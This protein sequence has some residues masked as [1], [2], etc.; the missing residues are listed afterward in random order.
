MENKEKI[1][2]QINDLIALRSS[3]MTYLLVLT[4][5]LIGLFY[6]INPLNIFLLITGSLIGWFILCILSGITKKL[7]KLYK[8]LGGL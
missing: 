7:N 4:G 6:N 3:Y 2:A 5:G 8:I 1:N